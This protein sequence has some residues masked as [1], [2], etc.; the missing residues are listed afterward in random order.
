MLKLESTLLRTFSTV[1]TRMVEC[2]QQETERGTSN[3]ETKDGE[4][5]APALHS[6][7]SAERKLQFSGSD[8]R[9]LSTYLKAPLKPCSSLR[10]W[11]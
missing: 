4:A 1:G 10:R 5:V 11:T 8:T 7:L 3:K 6:R 2:H 9:T